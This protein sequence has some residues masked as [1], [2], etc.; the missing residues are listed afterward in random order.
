MYLLKQ[1]FQNAQIMR[2]MVPIDFVNF[3][4]LAGTIWDL[5]IISSHIAAGKLKLLS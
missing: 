2:R 1:K 5:Q 3:I 4:L